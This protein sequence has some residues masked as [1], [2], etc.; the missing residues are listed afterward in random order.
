MT[1]TLLMDAEHALLLSCRIACWDAHSHAKFRAVPKSV[2][3]RDLDD[4]VYA[5]LARVDLVIEVTNLHG[6]GHSPKLSMR[7]RI[8]TC[9]PATEWQCV[10]RI[11]QQGHSHPRGYW[12]AAAGRPA[13]A[14]Q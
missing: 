14:N 1:V 11:H 8:P 5:G 10:F 9:N 12:L 13:A 4:E 7:V 3:I 2:Q 6:L